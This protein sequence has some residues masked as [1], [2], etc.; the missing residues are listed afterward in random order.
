MP[1]LRRVDP[2]SPGITRS[3]RGKGFTYRTSSGDRLGDE[4]A[5]AR[6][7]ALVIPPAWEDVWISPLPHGHIQAV[8]TDQAGRRQYLYHTAWREQRD[9]EKFDRVL[10][11][12]H[13]LPRVRE[14]V[15]ADLNQRGLVRERVLSC[16]VRLLDLGFFRIGGEEYAEAHGSYGLATMLREHVSVSR[17]V[18]TFE[19]PAKSGRQ[20]IQSVADDAV[21]SVVRARSYGGRA[22]VPSCLPTGV[23]ATGWT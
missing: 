9:L 1:R 6:I 2:R 22:A 20:R 14:Q 13:R 19:Y 5:L 8:G 15:F 12:A 23:G 11:F 7:R 21:V 10:E 16:A 18:V 17:R 3:R 4:D